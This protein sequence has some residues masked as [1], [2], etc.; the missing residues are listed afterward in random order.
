MSEA[1]VEYFLTESG[2]ESGPYTIQ[3]IKEMWEGGSITAEAQVRWG[4]RQHK[5]PVPYLIN[6]HYEGS[7]SSPYTRSDAAVVGQSD[8]ALAVIRRYGDAYLVAGVTTGFGSIIK[9]IGIVLAVL[10]FGGSI[11][12]SQA[13]GGPFI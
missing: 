7:V 1:N 9:G 2:M 6:L 4:A 3:Q 5:F 13:Y 10:T 12:A 11:F 8:Y